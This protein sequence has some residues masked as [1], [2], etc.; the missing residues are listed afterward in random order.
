VSS[1]VGSLTTIVFAGAGHRTAME[2]TTV[3]SWGYLPARSW[4]GWPANVAE[5]YSFAIDVSDLGRTQ[6][7]ISIDWRVDFR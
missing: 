2:D 4:S 6:P 3:T 1:G 7:H 5:S